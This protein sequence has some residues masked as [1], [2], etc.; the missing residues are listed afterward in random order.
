M[1]TVTEP[2][3]PATVAASVRTDADGLALCI[4]LIL[5]VAI[6]ITAAVIINVARVPWSIVL[7]VTVAAGFWTGRVS[8][9]SR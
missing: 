2:T 4:G 7:A 6:T 3:S 8:R 9:I 1:S 5:T